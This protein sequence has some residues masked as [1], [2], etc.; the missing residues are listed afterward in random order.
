M[1]FDLGHAVSSLSKLALRTKRRM[2]NNQ[3]R[4]E[5][6]I[7]KLWM[8][9]TYRTYE[10]QSKGG[11]KS[12]IFEGVPVEDRKFALIV[13]SHHK[14]EVNKPIGDVFSVDVSSFILNESS[15]RILY[16]YIKD[17]TQIFKIQ[18]QDGLLYVIN[19]TDVIDCLDYNQ[20]DIKYFSSS[21]R[22]M[23]VIKYVFINSKLKNAI[24]FKLPEFPS[25]IYVTEEFKKVV[26]DNQIKG[27][28][29]EEL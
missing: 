5:Q 21:N 23:R 9:H 6:K 26:E 24:I 25:S 14:D 8:D 3:L 1:G 18:H 22:V 28:K 12:Y 19:V 20:S 4:K 13:P 10:P 27:F 11:Y 2:D 15:F 17:H 16:L 29:F 7:Y